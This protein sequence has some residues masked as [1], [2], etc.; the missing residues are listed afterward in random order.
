MEETGVRA[1]AEAGRRRGVLEEAGACVAEG[2]RVHPVTGVGFSHWSRMEQWVGH[3]LRTCF[4]ASRL[5]GV[6][7]FPEPVFSR[8]LLHPSI[9]PDL[10]PR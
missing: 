6:P 7:V 2:V 8:H 5:L 9:L 10:V 1:S 4:V 3:F